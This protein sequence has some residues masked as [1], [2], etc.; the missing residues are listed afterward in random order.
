[1]KAGKILTRRRGCGCKACRQAFD[2]IRVLGILLLGTATAMA[3]PVGPSVVAGAAQVTNPSSTL[4]TV[5]QSSAKAIINWQ[6]FSVSAGG[7]VQFNQPNSAAITL[8]R[9]TGGNISSV[10][11][12]VKA[13]GQVWLLNPNGVL[14]G[15]GANINVGGLLATT[16]DIANQDFLDG[17]YNFSGGKGAVTNN[18]AIHAGAGGSVVLSAPSVA[19]NGLIEAEAGHVVL[20][21][22]DTFTVDFNGDHLLS[23]A[24][25]PGQAGSAANSGAISAPGGKVLLTARAASD[26]AAGVVNNTGM[27][28]ATS[29]RQENGE[30]ILDAGDT[31]D[32]GTL[33]A[34]GKAGGQTG[35]S[36]QL[37]GQAVQVTD[38]A[39]IDVS[40][41]AG[42]GQVLIGG[43]F[44][45]EGPE[46]NAQM[47]SVGRAT[48]NADAV[49]RGNGG[50]VAIW[51]NGDTRFSG[52]ISAKGGVAAGNGGQVETSGHHL[53]VD[54]GVIVD[55]RAPNGRTG[56]WLLDPDTIN[57]NAN[58]SDN[59]STVLYSDTPT[60]D[61]ISPAT[62]TSLLQG[63]AAPGTNVT[64]QA[65]NDIIVTDPINATSSKTLEL[66]AGHSIILNASITN[67]GGSIIL[68]AG[69][70]AGGS[71]L[72][73]P[74]ITGNTGVTLSA[75]SVSLQ[76]FNGG[77][78]D[79]FTPVL[80]NA[81]A[82]TLNV[83]GGDAYIQ[84]AS[85]ITIAGANATGI[86]SLDSGGAIT[87]T[88][89]I[90]AGT[91]T[92]NTSGS[93]D[94]TLTNA[95]NAV[96]TLNLFTS[97]TNA[98]VNVAS[99]VILGDADA[100]DITV[101]SG[102]ALTVGGS[103]FGTSTTTLNAAN[104]IIQSGGQGAN[105]N[106]NS[107]VLDGGA[108]DIGSTAQPLQLFHDGGTIAL[109]VAGGTNAYFAAT[110]ASD[111]ALNNI[112]LLN[113]AFALITQGSISYSS[114]T[115][116]A[117]EVSLKT[118]AGDIGAPGLP[119]LVSQ[120]N[121][122]IVSLSLFTNDFNAFV[123]VAN[124]VQIAD[125]GINGSP[126]IAL[127]GGNLTLNA[128]GA[129][130]QSA[131][132]SAAILTVSS[133][134]AIGLNDATN[135]VSGLVTL[136]AASGSPA[137][138]I[139]FSNSVDTILGQVMADANF[140]PANS[141]NITVGNGGG[142]TL[143]DE[144]SVSGPAI[145]TAD[146]NITQN[147]GT[148]AARLVNLT[149]NSGGIGSL[150]TPFLVS[151]N[152]VS[153]TTA[154][155]DVVLDL[156]TF[157]TNTVTIGDGTHGI[158]AGIGNVTVT[159]NGGSLVGNVASAGIIHAHQLSVS[160]V[161]IDLEAGN[162]VSGAIALNSGN[163]VIFNNAGATTLGGP[164]S[165]I[166]NFALTSAG[167]LTILGGE[168]LSA[169][170]SFTLTAAGNLTISAGSSVT[171]GQGSNITL[172]ATGNFINNSG[173]GAGTLVLSGGRFLVYS[174]APA[175]DIFGGLNSNNMAIWGT[176]YPTAI[177][178]TGNRYVFAQQPTITV[179]AASLAKTYG[180]DNSAALAADT[181]TLSG[182]QS[183]VAGAF[184]ADTAAA[185]YN[186]TPVLAS[187]GTAAGAAVSG[188]PY[189]ITLVN[190]SFTVNNG[191]RIAVAP[192]TITVN[193]ATL[194]YAATAASR[195]YGV[196]NPAFGGTVT[197]FVNG[198]TLASATTG[199]LAFTS[200]ATAA[201]GVGNYAI[202]G[203][204]LSA[205]NYLF[206]QAA[207]N[208]TALKINPAVLTIA[209]TGTV[210]KV[211]DGTNVATLAAA[212]YTALSGIVGTDQVSLASLP[213]TGAYD[214]PAVGTGKTVT[215][216]GLALTGASVANYTIA[217]SVSG[218]VGVILSASPP[219]TDPPLLGF[220]V[221]NE[222]GASQHFDDIIFVPFGQSGSVSNIP[223][224]LGLPPIIPPP[225]P[226]PPP[227]PPGPLADLQGGPQDNGNPADITT[228]QVASSLDGG[229]PASDDN[230]VIIPGLLVN[231]GA[232]PPPTVAD[233]GTLSSWGNTSL[234]Q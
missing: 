142:L 24:M 2:S 187:A 137:N 88:G 189:A 35:G 10:Q 139:E 97:N 22:T 43:N 59:R 127:N 13:N 39:K 86:L 44:H 198:E 115:I 6:D 211:F 20:G 203:S 197:G 161:D 135:Q 221:A 84:S 74:V 75:T 178:Q 40:G 80:V 118:L 174:A 136:Y 232:S 159:A 49:T 182:L 114:N 228:D 36:V 177:S 204:G 98:Q 69:N 223:Q 64:L 121:N 109:Q 102:G 205:G 227:P 1:M 32:S 112:N 201:S 99:S 12:A 72:T 17:H 173:L 152:A 220:T 58:G 215:V 25:G 210:S 79:S 192:A 68:T 62:I 126:G 89:A 186:G 165:A 73:N 219:P 172:S 53:Q 90:A 157:D 156:D 30:I 151:T 143:T 162:H 7:T 160:A 117:D 91:L 140:D 51:S 202:N 145:L 185:I 144:V 216:T 81:N 120:P 63:G 213:T 5:N 193:R 113:G 230:T 110:S 225:L 23:Y 61:T 87:Q 31:A 27:V 194:T 55:T 34:S 133:V 70:P 111:I 104:G 218:P 52:S 57:I 175:G 42:G 95:G 180:T 138:D 176:T 47:T 158:D 50:Q 206:V 207:G 9:V 181:V 226:P 45:G 85:D 188:S 212:N 146:G 233:S 128:A 77:I 195:A 116:Y 164:N 38:N 123:S 107:I 150:Q 56:N 200:P 19:N 129:I 190:G 46:P 101:T 209:L 93:S 155:G 28:A 132:I 169:G 82:L 4:T 67:T 92:L 96:G 125:L 21:G 60:N 171:A 217:S 103:I 119:I 33:D 3:Q 122:V 184:L 130:T 108:G 166:G 16:S 18:G 224:N 100:F 65:V 191:Y 148:L 214:T 71:A 15:Q 222:Q 170:G 134:G 168:S 29:A 48:I 231:A 124:P 83:A 154:G 37:L 149:S 66:D 14:I 41:D 167:D 105:I 196:A 106:S 147:G 26:V 208:A 183:G 229:P 54:N 94:I 141:V 199:T 163:N 8:N 179:T 131:P 78:G 153:A 11:G 76:N 234:W